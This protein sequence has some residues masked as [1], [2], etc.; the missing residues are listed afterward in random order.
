MQ[1]P[2]HVCFWVERRWREHH[3]DADH[4]D[5]VNHA[6]RDGVSSSWLVV[7]ALSE[8]GPN[9]DAVGTGMSAE[10]S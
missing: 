5:F 1:A 3:G 10:R 8:R 9:D 7:R 4:P 6:E 2:V